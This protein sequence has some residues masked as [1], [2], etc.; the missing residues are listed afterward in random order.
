MLLAFLPHALHAKAVLNDQTHLKHVV[1][2]KILVVVALGILIYTHG[3]KILNNCCP[4]V[5][6]QKSQ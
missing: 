5:I 6:C 3:Q 2:G 4:F 1:T